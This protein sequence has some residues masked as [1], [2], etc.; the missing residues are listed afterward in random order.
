MS[1]DFTFAATPTRYIYVST[2]GSD[3]GSHAAGQPYKTIQAAVNAATPGTAIMV[4]AGTYTENVK[5][6]GTGGT[7]DKPIWLISAD[8]PQAAQIV[9]ANNSVSTIKGLGT[10]NY[11]IKDFQISGGLNGI[12]F[13]QSGQNFTNMVTNVLIEGNVIVNTKEDGIKISQAD[14]VSV[15]NNVIRNAGQEAI[16]FVAVQ[17]GTIAHNE[18]V[19]TLGNSAAIFAKAGSSDILIDSNYV[20]GGKS[21]GIVVGGWSG[22]SYDANGQLLYWRPGTTGYEARDVV[23]TNNVITDVS[24]RPINV[25]GG[26]NV[27]I[28]HNFLEANPTYYT[29]INVGSGSPQSPRPLYSSNV[30][31]HDNILSQDVRQLYIEKGSAV[32]V[33]SGNSVAS[34][35]SIGAMMS[36]AGPQVALKTDAAEAVAVAPVA[37][38]AVIKGG[39]G[40]D[41]LV[42]T[43]GN[44]TIDGGSGIDTMVGG[45]GDDTYVVGHSRDIV[46]EKAG[47]G[48]DTVQL[49]TKD[50]VLADNVEKLLVKHAAGGVAAGNDLA[51]VIEGGGGDDIIIGGRGNDILT[52]GTGADTFVFKSGDGSDTIT[53]F[54]AMDRI[55][56]SSYGFKSF[57][58]LKAGMSQ[59]GADV[60]IDLGH[61]ETLTL[62]GVALADLKASQFDIGATSQKAGWSETVIGTNRIA[63]SAQSDAAVGTDGNDYIN[64]GDGNDVMMGGKGDDLYFV[65][66]QGDRV[67]EFAGEGTDSIVLYLKSYVLDDNVENLT[68]KLTDGATVTGNALNNIIKGGTGDDVIKGGG[69]SD[70]LWGM[71]G[72]NI[73]VYDAADEGGDVIR[74]FQIGSD[75]LDLRTLAAN[76]STAKVSY[77][78]TT[79]GL[80]VLVS[81][82][83]GPAHVLATLQGVKADH[84]T[85]GVD[86]LL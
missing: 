5:L 83:G 60:V 77:H 51:N 76:D 45:K 40:A 46:V 6:P 2:T 64:P 74:D 53:D 78:L 84:L 48:Y 38:N 9:A 29:T 81:D 80:E 24:K 30:D 61:A 66:Q 34:K 37:K 1:N 50:Y 28:S 67:V 54:S 82:H 72:K 71:G 42:G 55:A 70:Q 58:A 4:S 41:N 18:A 19:N 23:V 17:H 73:F 62:K 32:D 12:Q 3:A 49:W 16:D 86:V 59:K 75:K 85:L 14:N 25:L 22:F 68:V 21:D 15:I 69:G 11:V 65:Y 10:D 31:I 43:D 44:D 35:S 36:S 7:A 79:T 20:H 52:G 8:G 33:F 56:L 39:S 47:E 27:D 26:Q 63:S 57:D 13:S